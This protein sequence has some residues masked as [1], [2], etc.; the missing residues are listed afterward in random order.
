MG[1]LNLNQNICSNL[2]IKFSPFLIKKKEKRKR[3]RTVKGAQ[4]VVVPG[5]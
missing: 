5:K 3:N 1:S 4:L 2:S